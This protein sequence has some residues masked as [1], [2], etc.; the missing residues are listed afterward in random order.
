MKK[1]IL[2]VF[3]I[4]SA[5]YSIAQIS[6]TEGKI[7]Y[8][9]FITTNKD[10]QQGQLI[11]TLKNNMMK[12][13]MIMKNGYS[14]IIL[15]D[16]NTGKSTVYSMLNGNKLSKVLSKADVLAQNQKFLSAK[17]NETKIQKTIANKPCA[18]VKITYTDGSQNTVF[19][20]VDYRVA[21][22]EF[23]S[24][25][26][27]LQGMPMQYQVATSGNTIL[28]VA[29]SIEAKP[30]DNIEMEAPMGYKTMK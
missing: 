19:Y 28:L 14:N 7:V 4:L 29:K 17:Y 20:N 11:I 8:D 21:M 1:I 22:K 5:L 12:R 26:P 3:I 16:V 24:M 23:Y 13:E 18:E 9:I 6:I 27:D 10:E 15:F 25:F 30:V 2:S